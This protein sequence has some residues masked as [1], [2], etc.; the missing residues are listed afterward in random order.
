MKKI[1]LYL[2]PI[3]LV[4][5]SIIASLIAFSYNRKLD[6]GYIDV[7]NQA[8]TASYEGDYFT[9]LGNI[10]ESASYI[11]V[12]SLSNHVLISIYNSDKIIIKE[13]TFE[14]KKQGGNYS[15][16]IINNVIGSDLVSF[17]ELNDYIFR[18]DLEE[19]VTYEMSFLK[20]SNNLD[21]DE[22]DLILVNIPDHLLNMKNLNEG[23]AFTTMIFAIISGI[24]IL[25]F[26]LFKKG[27]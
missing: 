1:I 11:S 13:Y 7:A 22:I 26:V 4:I 17:D 14:I 25:I 19:N 15:Q 20:T 2:V 18:V 5:I 16:E 3:F 21:D 9:V 6:Y 10:G 12:E 8:V 27:E 24:T 23:I